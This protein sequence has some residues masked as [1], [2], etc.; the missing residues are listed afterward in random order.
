MDLSGLGVSAAYDKKRDLGWRSLGYKP[1]TLKEMIMEMK[2]NN[3]DKTE[4]EA[5]IN[6]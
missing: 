3:K 4:L 5:L 2:R 1:Q 6:A